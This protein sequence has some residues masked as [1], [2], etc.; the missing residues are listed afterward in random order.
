MQLRSCAQS[1]TDTCDTYL[2][3]C[4][5]RESATDCNGTG[6]R[7]DA[8][9]ARDWSWTCTRPAGPGQLGQRASACDH[10][11]KSGVPVAA[12]TKQ[13]QSG[14]ATL[15]SATSH[16]LGPLLLFPTPPPSSNYVSRSGKLTAYK[17]EERFPSRTRNSSSGEA[18]GL[19]RTNVS[20]GCGV[21]ERG[22]LH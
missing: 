22:S 6:V 12:T 15:W 2:F 10:P 21:G 19:R 14:E 20:H 4:S 1:S 3:M 13:P 17:V 16:P 9:A 18:S 11:L 8:S 5:T 7:P